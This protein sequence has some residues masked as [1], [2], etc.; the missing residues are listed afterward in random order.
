MNRKTLSIILG[1][2]LVVVIGAIVYFVLGNKSERTE[3]ARKE[4]IKKE[5]IAE[6]KKWPGAGQG[7]ITEE[8]APEIIEVGKNVEGWETYKNEE[9]GYE[10]DYLAKW[11]VMRR[12]FSSCGDDCKYIEDLLIQNLP[13]VSFPGNG[14]ENGSVF[15]IRIFEISSP[16]NLTIR[17][18]I[19]NADLPTQQK[20]ARINRIKTIEIAE[21]N[22]EVS[23]GV[24][25]V[26]WQ[27]TITFV[28][29]NRVYEL[30][31]FSGSAGQ[32]SKDLDTFKKMLSTFGL[33][34]IVNLKTYQNEKYGF[35]LKYPKN[36]TLQDNVGSP[37]GPVFTFQR[38]N[39]SYCKFDISPS[40]TKSDINAEL[41]YYRQNGYKEK[42]YTNENTSAIRFSK[43]AGTK[44][45]EPLDVLFFG[46]SLNYYYRVSLTS[47]TNKYESDC[48]NSFTQILSTFKFTK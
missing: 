10:I 28:D 32:F 27:Q 39:G 6:A 25:D 15:G 34:G 29:A 33:S 8:T 26:D 2:L 13:F 30:T 43:S 40:G 9:A 45:L 3:V 46:N 38:N 16:S 4:Q 17:S 41:S 47:S 37:P 48:S 12:Q 18:W 35:E 44:N 7:G 5:M 1:V 19:E 24:V 36:W 11:I 14:P 20:E 23:T 31:Y 22:R 42:T 21:A